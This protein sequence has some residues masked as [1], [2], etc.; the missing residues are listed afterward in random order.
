MYRT[1]YVGGDTNS[2]AYARTD[3]ALYNQI[4]SIYND[5]VKAGFPEKTVIWYVIAVIY[6]ESDDLTS[7]V[8]TT[9]NNYAGIIYVPGYNSKGLPRP[10]SEG[11]YYAHYN[12][13]AEFAKQLLQV[14]SKR[15]KLGAP[16]D[17]T[18]A[19]DFQNRLYA[20]GF[21]PKSRYTQYGSIFNRKLQKINANLAWAKAQ[22]AQFL[23]QYNKGAT[24]Y[25]ADQQGTHTD[26]ATNAEFEVDEALNTG[27]GSIEKYA[28]E[29][30]V[31]A[32][33]TV[34]VA[35]LLVVKVIAK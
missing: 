29:H 4:I 14:L 20:N 23:A 19:Q 28:H 3:G 32:V 35:G 12:S 16:I 27:W 33:V 15:G 18:T 8:A 10:K 2:P 17:A 6:L 22:G 21:F 34:F 1:A 24:S 30:P 31:T 7:H 11:G 25:V 13:F 9:D 5:L 26:R